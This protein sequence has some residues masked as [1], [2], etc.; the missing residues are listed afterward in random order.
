VGG[1]IRASGREH[2]LFEH[3]FR[4]VLR[5]PHGAVIDQRSLRATGRRW[6]GALCFRASVGRAATVETAAASAKDG[7]LA[8]FVQVRATRPARS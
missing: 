7:A 4:I 6:S 3:Q 2:H 5:A 8:R 1:T